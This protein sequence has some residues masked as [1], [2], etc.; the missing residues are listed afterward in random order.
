MTNMTYVNAIDFA[1]NAVADNEEVVEKLTALKESL[2][3]RNTRKNTTMTKTQKE[4]VE[5][6]ERILNAL[7]YSDGMTATAV[8]ETVGISVAKATALLTQLKKAEAIER[9]Q[10]GKAVLFKVA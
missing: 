1:I 8:A 9:I 7:A 4:N 2:I 5:V 10:S 6:K 3:K